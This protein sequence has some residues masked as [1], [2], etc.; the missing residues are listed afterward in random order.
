MSV[1]WSGGLRQSVW[2]NRQVFHC[3]F[4]Y[5]LKLSQ[6]T[7]Q[8]WAPSS[9]SVVS[10]LIYSTVGDSPIVQRNRLRPATKE[11]VMNFYEKKKPKVQS[12]RQHQNILVEYFVELQAFWVVSSTFQIAQ[13]LVQ[14][15]F[16]LV[17]QVL[18]LEATEPVSEPVTQMA[19]ELISLQQKR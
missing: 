19:V 7:V 9:S 17:S 13:I 6:I 15:H 5:S 12:W 4:L 11:N 14:S 8:Q 2:D 3:H 1:Y 18:A 16:E 10:D